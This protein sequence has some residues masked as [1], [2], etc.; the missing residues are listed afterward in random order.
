MS[1][2]DE[3]DC[4]IKL[5]TDEPPPVPP[6]LPAF[7]MPRGLCHTDG[8]T[9]FLDVDESRIVVSPPASR[10]INVWFGDTPHARHAVALINV[11]SY[12][13]HMALRR[14]G[15]Y[16][17]HAAGVVEPTSGAGVL[18]V[19]ESNS[20]KSSL[21]VRLTRSGWS[22]L[23]DDML[24]A[25]EKTGG[26][27]ARAL[28]RLFAVSAKTLAGCQLPRLEEALGTPV[29]SDPTKRRLKPSIVFPESF[30]ES[31]TPR[32]ICFPV[33]TGEKE[34]RLE[35]M[36]QA[37]VLTRLIKLCAWTSF[38][39]TA[40]DYLRFLGRLVRQTKAYRLFAGLDL[41]DDPARAAALLKPY[42]TTA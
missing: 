41:L 23:S 20:G 16:D 29:N 38:D 2:A 11:M 32:V 6:H 26:I 36:R 34:S 17:L 33:I 39:A 12:V 21:T 18:F 37:D 27:E 13:M 40:R 14:C 15:L 3:I 7:E 8:E 4:T 42:V 24:V 28:R 5:W 9:Y 22:Y 35:V 25:Y 30:A 1:V 31:C 19:G 10:Q